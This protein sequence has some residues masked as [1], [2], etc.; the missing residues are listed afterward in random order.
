MRN[1]KIRTM[2][3]LVSAILFAA[4]LTGIVSTVVSTGGVRDLG[5]VWTTFE[6]GAA[7]KSEHILEL[8]QALGYGGMIHHFK[9]YVLRKDQDRITKINA[10][11]RDAKFAITA[12]RA[13]GVD[14]HERA[15]LLEIDSVVDAY[16]R[17][18]EVAKKMA[19][20]GR[21]SNEIDKVVK[22]DDSPALIA[23]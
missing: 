4:L 5:Q 16:L 2:A 9:N 6:T 17:G 14:E 11:A 7:Q 23:I 3:G 18:I 21:T 13:L 1:L 15:A 12:Y 22:V 19:G 8:E 20:E 10:S